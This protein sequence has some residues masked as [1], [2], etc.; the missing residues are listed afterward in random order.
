MK[1][2]LNIW[3]RYASLVSWRHMI[4]PIPY[5]SW[6]LDGSLIVVARNGYIDYDVIHAF[7]IRKGLSYPFFL[8]SLCTAEFIF[9]LV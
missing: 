2:T 7:N 8:D 5:S 4:F 1:S 3:Y 9:S 6:P